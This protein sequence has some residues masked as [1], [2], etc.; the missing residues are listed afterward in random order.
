MERRCRQESRQNGR[1]ECLRYGSSGT[2]GRFTIYGPY[3]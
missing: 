1:Q 2:I 3:F